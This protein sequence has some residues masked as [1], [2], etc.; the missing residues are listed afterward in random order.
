MEPVKK[1]RQSEQDRL[2][3]LQHKLSRFY[4]EAERYFQDIAESIARYYDYYDGHQ[5][6]NEE[7]EELESR[8]QPVIKFNLM[9]AHIN[10][11]RGTEDRTKLDVS[12]KGRGEDDA[13]KSMIY[14]AGSKFV[15]DEND[16]PF[17]ISEAFFQQSCGGLGVLYTGFNPDPEGPKILEEMVDYRDVRFDPKSK[18]YDWSIDSRYFIRKGW[19]EVDH[20]INV[21]PEHKEMLKESA[22]R[23]LLRD[24]T[25][26]DA[27][28]YGDAPERMWYLQGRQFGWR[29]DEWRDE[30]E[31]RVMIS[32]CWYKVYVKRN[33]LRRHLT[34]EQS[35]I[36]LENPTPEQVMLMASEPYEII[37]S[38]PVNRWRVAIFAG[39]NILSDEAS[40]YA[41][42]RLPYIPFWGQREFRTGEYYGIAQPM[43]DP[44][45]MV[46]MSLSKLLYTIGTQQVW[47]ETGAFVDDDIAAEQKNDPNGMVECN[48]GQLQ[49][50][51]RDKWETNAQL[52]QMV[53]EMSGKILGEGSGTNAEFM[54]RDS[55]ADSGYGIKLRQNAASVSLS[56][57]FKNY[58]KSLKMLAELRLTNIQQAFTAPMFARITDDP[59][60]ASIILNDLLYIPEADQFIPAN[61]ITRSKIDVVVSTEQHED[62]IRQAFAEQLMQ[63]ISRLPDEAVIALLDLPIEMGDPPRKDQVLQRIH[64]VQQMLLGMDTTGGAGAQNGRG[65]NGGGS[66]QLARVPSKDQPRSAAAVGR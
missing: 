52:Q 32:E 49:K 14:R 9:Q 35:E 57:I 21:W 10:A 30:A 37:E 43:M 41:H 26:Q 13:R 45:D 22:G 8:D 60:A 29:S 27:V 40:P 16:T 28:P 39:P 65:N 31:N 4:H 11:V 66:P 18:K 23:G 34:G 42:N 44:Q 24:S 20:A 55:G 15:E 58:R 64:A 63:M 61:T 56:S 36:D 25:G 50:I 17:E 38:A 7:R 51:V 12:Y 1:K 19:W 54:G 5:F 53:M 46:N 47:Y 48:A 62:S 3:E 33:L 59:E 2:T 6:T